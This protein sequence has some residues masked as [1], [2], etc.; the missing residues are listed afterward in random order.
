[1]IVCFNG[2]CQVGPQRAASQS[3]PLRSGV[4]ENTVGT[5]Q[6]HSTYLGEPRG[7]YVTDLSGRMWVA[8]LLQF[9]TSR[10]PLPLTKAS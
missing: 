10:D 3:V 6:S 1:M 2:I 7:R 4:P 8:F 5:S 9:H